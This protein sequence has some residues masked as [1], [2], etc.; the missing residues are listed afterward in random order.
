[1]F[2]I[3]YS[4]CATRGYV[5]AGEQNG[6]CKMGDSNKMIQ[7]HDIVRM[8]EKRRGSFRKNDTTRVNALGNFSQV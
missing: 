6:W 1:M 8:F 4:A 2:N 3:Y 5:I 7:Q